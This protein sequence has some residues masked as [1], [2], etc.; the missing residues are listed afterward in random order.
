M[1]AMLD[2]ELQQLGWEITGFRPAVPGVDI[3]VANSVVPGILPVIT[4][5]IDLPSKQILDLIKAATTTQP[6]D[7]RVPQRDCAA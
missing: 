5:V 3:E 6:P 7:S 1:D 4:S 2:H